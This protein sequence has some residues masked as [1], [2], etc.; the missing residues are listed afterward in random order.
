MRGICRNGRMS[1][2]PMALA[3][4]YDSFTVGTL[5]REASGELMK[6]FRHPIPI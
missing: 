3:T 2:E 6:M 5:A 1:N 4:G